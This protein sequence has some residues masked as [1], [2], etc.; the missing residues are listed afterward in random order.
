MR[1]HCEWLEQD[2]RTE[3]GPQP[4]RRRSDKE[5]L[6]TQLVLRRGLNDLFFRRA[7]ERNNRGGFAY[8]DEEIFATLGS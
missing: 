8:V 1:Q 4:V 2:I 3:E 6:D 7:A 5:N